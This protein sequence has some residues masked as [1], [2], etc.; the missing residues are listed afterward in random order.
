M[1]CGYGG[2]VGGGNGKGD[3]ESEDYGL[4]TSNAFRASMNAMACP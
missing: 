4:P 3:D 1:Q 2:K